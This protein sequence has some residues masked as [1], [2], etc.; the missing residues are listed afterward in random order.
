MNMHT[1][2][3]VQQIEALQL[4]YIDALDSKDMNGWLETFDSKG[5]Y[6]CRTAESE[7]R[8]LDISLILDDCHER[9]QDRVK[10]ITRVWAGTFQDYQTRHFVQRLDSRQLDDGLYEM[11]S[12]FT[13]M[14]TR[15]DTGETALFAAGVYL[16][17]VSI[18]REGASFRSKKAIIDAP[19]LPHYMVYPL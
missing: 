18:G 4:R 11:R 6:I 12:N 5:S 2:N 15:S 3:M 19:I 9:L 7:T 16:D 1:P 17:T 13:V 14:F 10:F 8:G